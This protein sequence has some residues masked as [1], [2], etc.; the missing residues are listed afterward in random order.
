MTKTY[1]DRSCN[2]CIRKPCFIGF[3][4]CKSDFAKFGC[5]LYKERNDD[6]SKVSSTI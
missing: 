4:K 5:K 3:E 1:K 2:K 6:I